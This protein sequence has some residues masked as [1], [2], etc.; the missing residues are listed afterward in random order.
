MALIR[1]KHQLDSLTLTYIINLAA[2][3]KKEQA[4]NKCGQGLPQ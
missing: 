3:K 4:G 2:K 1:K